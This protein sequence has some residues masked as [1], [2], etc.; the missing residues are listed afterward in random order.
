MVRRII[1]NYIQS[2][3]ELAKPDSVRLSVAEPPVPDVFII[4][5]VLALRGQDD[6]VELLKLV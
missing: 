1:L 3:D 4:F 2:E 6:L 5:V